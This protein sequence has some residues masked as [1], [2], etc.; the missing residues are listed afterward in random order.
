MFA[1]LVGALVVE[2]LRL[3]PNDRF[4]PL[5]RLVSRV[6]IAVVGQPDIDM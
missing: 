3:P 1:S 6:E 2:C 4:D 5:H